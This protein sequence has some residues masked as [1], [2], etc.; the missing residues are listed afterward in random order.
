MTTNAD[1]IAEAREKVIAISGYV[2]TNRARDL[3]PKLADALEA[4][5]AQVA[6]FG[7]A[8][9]MAC[10]IHTY[11]CA[12]PACTKAVATLRRYG[13]LPAPEESAHVD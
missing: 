12:H 11:D 13:L 3:I 6:R 4:S 2:D 8:V 7:A 1:L 10:D 9:R 5:Q